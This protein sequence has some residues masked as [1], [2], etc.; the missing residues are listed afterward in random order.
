MVN[1]LGM[2]G[3][4]RQ[5]SRR[6]VAVLANMK[7]PNIVQYKESFEGVEDLA[8][9]SMSKLLQISF[10]KAEQVKRQEKQ[11]SK[12]EILR[13]LNENLKA[14]EDEKEKHPQSDSCE[15]VCH[16]DAKEYEKENAI[17]SDRKKWEVGGQLVIPLDEVTLDSSFSEAE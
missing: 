8:S 15:I 9:E 11:R 10:L 1:S 12:R 4:E 13:R 6:E 2:S 16:K 17:S 7:H 5:E 14:Q 3:K